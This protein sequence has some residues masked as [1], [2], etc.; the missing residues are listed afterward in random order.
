ML[1]EERRKEILKMI[2]NS[3][4]PVSGAML[5]KE[6]QV[7]RQVIVQDIALL[8]AAN[9]EILATSKGYIVHSP[10][11]VER[12]VAVFHSDEDILE[13]LNLIVDN[14]GIVKDVFIKH[15]VYGEIRGSLDVSSRKKAAAFMAE[16]QN[17]KSRP[18][19]NITS[20]YHFHTIAADSE[21]TLDSIIEEL[22]AH[23]YVNEN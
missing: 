2:E 13:E 14:G 7:S 19:K 8:R 12:V 18:L 10:R 1:G 3:E 6:F 23:G 9:V 5:S 11:K 22:K 4:S 17:G 20:G 21:H 16:I 15:E